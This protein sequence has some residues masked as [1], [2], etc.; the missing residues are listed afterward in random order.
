MA[1]ALAGMDAALC[2][3]RLPARVPAGFYLSPL[4][5]FEAMAAGLPVVA[6]RLGQIEE[7]VE[8]GRSG[9]LVGDDPE[10]AVRALET[11]ARSPRERRAM[12]AAALERIRGGFTWD[13]TAARVESVLYEASGLAARELP[14][15][16]VA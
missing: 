2:L 3:Y 5:V 15:R 11:L 16:I 1:A 13:H 8:A 7:V 14:R 10:E 4:K 12:G 9:V 6:S